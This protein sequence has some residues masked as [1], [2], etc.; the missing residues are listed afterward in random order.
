MK[1]K[2]MPAL[3]APPGIP[4]VLDTDVFSDWDKRRPH[5]VAAI[6]SYLIQMKR[7]P[8]LTTI[9]VFEVQNGFESVVAKSGSLEQA[10]QQMR[11]QAEQLIQA[12]GVLEFNQRAAE[13]AAYIYSRLAHRHQ[14]KHW[15]DVF[16]AATALAHGRGV[17]TRN[18]ADF[19]L[20]GNHLP[21]HCQ[22]LY[23]AIWKP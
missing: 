16:I 3:S 8:R 6:K 5:T 4:L 13:I 12:C 21:Q 1:K 15:R 10:K 18:K 11:T 7:P 19:E 20:I 22:I 17:A 23:L 2:R 14:N 9:T